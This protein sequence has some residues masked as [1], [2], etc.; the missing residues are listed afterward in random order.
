MPNLPTT[1]NNPG[2]L[3]F[4]G[5]QGATDS[6]S[7][8]A[9]FSSPQEGFGALLNDLQ[10]KIKNH[11]DATLADFSNVYAPPSE[12]NTAQYTAN[13]ANQLGVPPNATIGSLEPKIGKFAEAIASN[14]GY[15]GS[16]PALDSSSKTSSS[17]SNFAPAAAG[18]GAGALAAGG[19][20]TLAT[21]GGDFLGGI[22]GDV[23]GW[24]Q[25]A[26]GITGLKDAITNSAGGGNAGGDGGS[27]SATSGSIPPPQG[28]PQN[29]LPD[30]EPQINEEEKQFSS[31]S[32]SALASVANGIKNMLQ[33]NQSGRL[34]SS[35]PSGQNAIGTATA[36]NLVSQDENGNAVFDEN[37]RK[38]ALSEVANLDDKIAGASGGSV[39]PLLVSNLAGNEIAQNRLLT[40][41]DRQ[42]TAD[43]I[44]DEMKADV[45]S[46]SPTSRVSAPRLRELAKQHNAAA[47]NAYKEGNYTP[48]PK[49]MAHKALGRA[50]ANALDKAL[51][52]DPQAQELHRR[53][54]KMEQHL[55][56][57]KE[58]KKYIHGKKIPKNNGLWQSFLRQ[59]ARAAEI[60][61]GEKIGGPVGA[62]IG[63]MVGEGFNRR[64]TSH[65][66]KNILS[67][68]GMRAAFRTL[69]DTKPKEYNEL[70]A[71]L[72]KK[73]V[74]VPED[75]EKPPTT[76]A[77]MAKHIE[78]EEKGFTGKRGLVGF[79]P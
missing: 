37:A 67:T 79:K 23:G 32:S 51:E 10:T 74:T 53:A 6:P 5:Q 69:K 60:Y 42:K 3:R 28:Q 25:N 45:G 39:H 76:M 47:E 72:K 68:P 4:I 27:N 18:V 78:K 70:V 66:G 31:Q 50:Y 20:A 34:F 57:A 46:A 63:G 16:L 49:S 15:Q 22:L 2:D 61:I 73:G 21:D 48:T 52:G 17:T 56:R 75:N 36:F 65:F 30:E 1:N 54:M 38:Q 44:N 11:P 7:G 59:G 41:S 29:K 55:I 35:N 62:I 77:G 13:L 9:K 64:I 26:L 19:I 14:E 12:N 40:A 58:L 33:G 43:I 24:I 71:A 8:F